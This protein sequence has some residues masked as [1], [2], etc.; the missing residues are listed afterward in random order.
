MVSDRKETN[1]IWKATGKVFATVLQLNKIQHT[2][3]YV[4]KRNYLFNINK[5]NKY[6]T[7]STVTNR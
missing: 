5:K 4:I 1:S 6:P 2:A 7:V 3:S